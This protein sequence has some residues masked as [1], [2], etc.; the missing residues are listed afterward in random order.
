[1]RP[2]RMILMDL[3]TLWRESLNL[4]TQRPD[5]PITESIC[6]VIAQTRRT[7]LAQLEKIKGARPT[8]ARNNGGNT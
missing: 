5:C 1:M 4:K 3:E 8:R 2:E 7:V 6:G